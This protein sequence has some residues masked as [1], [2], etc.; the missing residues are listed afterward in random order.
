MDTTM[1]PAGRSDRSAALSR[2]GFLRV[3]GAGIGISMSSG[4]LAACGQ[5][6]QPAAPAP[7]D[8]SGEA[9]KPAAPATTAPAG[10]AGREV[11]LA[12][13]NAFS[14]PDGAFMKKMVDQYNEQNKGSVNVKLTVHP[15][16]QYYE[17]VGAALTSD[18]LPDVMIV[19]LDQLATWAARGAL[20]PVE[21][22]VAQVGLK[23]ED[24]PAPV[25][26]GREYQGKRYGIP[27]DIHPMTFYWNKKLLKDAGMDAPPK[28]AAAFE[29]AAQKLTQGNVKG[30]IQPIV[31]P[32]GPIAE[33]LLAQFVG[34]VT[35]EKGEKAA[36]N[37]DAGRK[38]LEYLLKLKSAPFSTPEVAPDAEANAFKDG[39]NAMT[40]NGIWMILGFRDAGVDFD[41][42]PVPQFGPEPRTWAGSHNVA[43]PVHK[44]GEDPNKIQAAGA[45]IG[46]LTENSAT[47]AEGGQIP[48]R[49]SAR[50]SAEF[51]RVLPQANIAP[52][53][54]TAIF[55]PPV[56]GISDA[57]AQYGE[58]TSDVLSGKKDVATAL[59]DAERQAH[60]LLAQN[61]EKYR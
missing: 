51:K 22:V 23:D 33:M 43:M 10:S 13:W 36:F 19:H 37:S 8:K 38:S 29:A 50:N 15:F 11:E 57:Y 47:W 1:S 52:S 16:A 45:F 58:A 56:P 61:R 21:S 49:L 26:K 54:D 55:P 6:A 35:D 25:W 18:T 14:G 7:A 60:D 48:A 39:T 3:L 44:K 46:W 20:Q 41:A 28:D 24:F 2:R 32:A 59:A 53:V 42:G 31:F 27:L 4:L 40:L 34:R 17:K 9:A 30:Y 5:G 12:Y